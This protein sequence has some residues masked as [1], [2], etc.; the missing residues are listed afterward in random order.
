MNKLITA[1]PCLL[2]LFSLNASYTSAAPTNFEV[3]VD[4]P[5]ADYINFDIAPNPE[6]CKNSCEAQARCQAYAYSQPGVFGPSA[7]CWL[8]DAAPLPVSSGTTISGVKQ[9]TVEYGW[10]R[11][12]SDYNSF[13]LPW[14]ATVQDCQWYCRNDVKCKAYTF[15]NAYVQNLTPRCWLKDSVPAP[16]ISGHTNTGTVNWRD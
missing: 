4:R 13:D 7:K 2:A 8:K 14:G 3:G 10:D 9:V 11:P 15:V 12:G 16:Q 6:A 1:L 5:G